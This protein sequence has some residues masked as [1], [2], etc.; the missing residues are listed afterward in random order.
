MVLPLTAQE[1]GIGEQL[2]EVTRTSHGRLVALLAAAGRD[3]AAAEDALADA[4]ER[5]L[6]RWP[7]DG[8]PA[9]PEAW[10]LVVARNRL[11]DDWKSAAHRSSVSFGETDCEAVEFAVATDIPDR[12]LALMMVCAHPA[13]AA[14]VRTPLMLQV[15][16][17]VDAAAIA[18]AFAV[19]PAAMAQRLVRAKKRIRDAGIPFVVPERERLTERLPAVLEA[20]YGAYAIDWQ[21]VP[22]QDPI[23]SLSGEAM[24]LA[25]LLA[26]LLPEE[27]EVLGLAALLCLSEARR[28]ARCGADG[29]FVPLDEQD[30][31]RWERPLISG[32]ERLLTRA[33]GYGRP[34]RFQY[35]AA[36]QSVHCS[37]A[38]PGPLDTDRKQTLRTLHRALM[39]ESPSLGAGV[40]LAALDGELDGPAAGLRALD[41]QGVAIAD[42]QP[43]VVVRA[44]LLAAAGRWTDAAT[45][46]RRAIGLTS[47]PWVVEYLE[48]CLRASPG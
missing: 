31:A 4:V 42:F 33:H 48:R 46:Y 10:L 7:V 17:G 36:I 24:H 23:E 39:R 19:E 1:P 25:V 6:L 32:G 26:E 40:A 45:S 2:A 28:P 20:V 29:S 3:I 41:A 13:I 5:A 47:T 37:R 44:H 34:G 16:L 15:V 8:V 22:Q 11:R 9:N 43:A 14:S 30:V 35:E 38:R 12:R 18:V 27:P 21:L